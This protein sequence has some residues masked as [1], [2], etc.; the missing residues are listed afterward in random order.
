VDTIK[1]VKAEREGS[2]TLSDESKEIPE[3]VP[4][5]TQSSPNIIEVFLSRPLKRIGAILQK[6]LNP[7]IRN[8]TICLISV[9]I[10]LAIVWWVGRGNG[11]PNLLTEVC[12]EYRNGQRI[13]NSEEGFNTCLLAAE[14]SSN[15]L[16]QFLVGQIY[17]N[18]LLGVE[19]DLD[20]ASR[21]YRKSAS[22]NYPPAQYELGKYHM[23]LYNP[24]DSAEHLTIAT[25]WFQASSEQGYAPAQYEL[26]NLFLYREEYEEALRW[27]RD[28]AEP[29]SEPQKDSLIPYLYDYCWD[30]DQDFKEAEK[31]YIQA[32]KQGYVFALYSIGEMYFHGAGVNQD[33]SEAKAW[34]ERA[35]HQGHLSAQKSLANIY[36]MGW[37]GDQDFDKARELFQNV[38]THGHGDAQRSL[39]AIFLFGIGVSHNYQEAFEWFQKSVD[40]GDQWGR[41]GLGLMY[42]NG[43]GTTND[44]EKAVELF[45]DVANRGLQ[46]AQFQLGQM[47]MNGI[48]VQRDS[49]IGR[50]WYQDAAEKG[51]APAQKSLADMYRR[52]QGMRQKNLERARSLYLL[53]SEQNYSPAQSTLGEMHLFGEGVPKSNQEA[54]SWFRRAATPKEI[55]SSPSWWEQMQILSGQS[56]IDG[57]DWGRIWLA[58]VITDGLR[59][60]DNIESAD[61][62]LKLTTD[63]N[64][65]FAVKLRNLISA[66][67]QDISQD[68][69]TQ[70]ELGQLFLIGQ[71]I[72]QDTEEAERWIRLSANQ[73]YADAQY[74]LALM[75]INKANVSK[76]AL[77]YLESAANQN[78][79]DANYKLYELYVG[80][81]PP[82]KKD[83]RK[84]LK[85]LKKA[86]DNCH[87]QA[88]F[89]IGQ[90]YRSGNE[91]AKNDIWAYAWINLS[92][93]Q[94]YKD[95]IDAQERLDVN[96]T[97]AQRAAIDKFTAEQLPSC[98]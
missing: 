4:S 47:Y 36:L 71:A 26:G 84:A 66:I 85:W 87:P 77:R 73:E 17:S 50:K 59:D 37:D 70:F 8:Y 11:T 1:K 27:Y 57:D 23:D 69:T 16:A 44:Y 5:V 75:L 35:F 51:Y 43:L 92:S 91:V 32:L 90:L 94:G 54:M 80:G 14:D 63:Q 48:G 13:Q 41:Y 39:G 97:S 46:E 7:P 33:I 65:V 68:A 62:L 3:D 52:G 74:H 45:R 61:S 34:Y 19:R 25:E 53:A 60:F 83:D 20:L 64:N 29:Q 18:N 40:V 6:I 93:K 21:W 76:E 2:S 88:Q 98:N 79:P 96:L 81:L 56:L 22:Q 89:Q 58:W 95:A 42:A 31:C 12:L 86:A 49:I 30:I 9:A 78:H 55:P 15:S 28:A 38:A 82:V 67:D 72:P 24:F 10:I